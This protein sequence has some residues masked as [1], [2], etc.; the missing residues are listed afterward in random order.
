MRA[1]LA[2]LAIAVALLAS[3]K[4]NK[5]CRASDA[6]AHLGRCTSDY[7]T[8]VVT[9]DDDCKRSTICRDHGRCTL[10]DGECQN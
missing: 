5:T 9:S 1:L 4:S 8:C 6:C 2:A 10:R 7:G 3:C